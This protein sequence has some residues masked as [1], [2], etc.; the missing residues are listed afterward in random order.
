MSG[1]QR[2]QLINECEAA[3]TKL[4]DILDSAGI[5]RALDQRG[6]AT[7][8]LEL[9]TGPKIPMRFETGPTMMKL[10]P[11]SPSWYTISSAT[12]HSATWML[13][14]AVPEAGPELVLKLDE[15][16][17]AASAQAAISASGL[18]VESYA[19]HYGHDPEPLIRDSRSRR[20][21]VDGW[22]RNWVGLQ[23]QQAGA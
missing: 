20:A 22:M 23:A 5:N 16:Q 13:R 15:M 4:E 3:V 10:L 19:L 1:Q 21:M 11:Q 12:A 17:V 14:Q 18:I 9:A 7:T 8:H 6:K 2:L